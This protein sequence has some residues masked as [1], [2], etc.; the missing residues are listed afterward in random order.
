MKYLLLIPCI[1]LFTISGFSQENKTEDPLK[2]SICKN[3]VFICNSTGSKAYHYS[4]ECKGLNRCNDT[5]K[6]ICREKAEKKFGRLHCG[7]ESKPTQ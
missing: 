4:K 1:Y 7:Y 6:S 3:E 2:K 5:I